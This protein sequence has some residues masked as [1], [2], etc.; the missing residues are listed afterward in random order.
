MKFIQILECSEV[1]GTCC[2]DYGLVMIFDIVRRFV[3][4][5]QILV[6]IILIVMTAVQ[7]IK[8]VTH[9]DDKAEKQARDKMI[10]NVI[11]TVLIFFLPVIVDTVMALLPTSESFQVAACWEL[12]SESAE[13]VRILDNDYV[14]YNDDDRESPIII[15]PGKYDPATGTGPNHNSGN[16]TSS[17][18]TP[19]G[20]GESSAT[21]QA[22]VQYA[23]QFVGQ[24]YVYGGSW[25]GEIPYTPTD[26]SGFVQGVFKHFGISLPRT[27]STQWAA[28]SKYTLVSTGDI[29]AGDL[30]MYDG[31]VG[32]L[33]GNG[34]E[35]IH[36]KGSK[37]GVVRDPD[38]RK[39]S[40]HAIKGIMRINGVN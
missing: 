29:R 7:C 13:V 26:C 38:Y 24:R 35:L 36:A 32:I 31:H 16:T 34:T 6:P 8:L 4:I 37:W 23:S 19:V 11:A 39:C 15:D 5:L 10:K 17:S 25:N 40:S 12:A 18:S 27:T 21:G 2:S 3:D 1:L 9:M 28:T 33:T 14:E 30:V 20:N 22:I